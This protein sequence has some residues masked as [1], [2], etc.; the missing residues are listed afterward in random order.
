MTLFLESLPAFY[1]YASGTV[2]LLIAVVTLARLVVKFLS[3]LRD[4]RNGS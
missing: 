4:Y 2:A 3:D 1:A